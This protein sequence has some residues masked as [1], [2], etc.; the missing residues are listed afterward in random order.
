MK[1]NYKKNKVNIEDIMS[2]YTVIGFSGRLNENLDKTKYK[3]QI[4]EKLSIYLPNQ[5]LS[6][7]YLASRMLQ[8]GYGGQYIILSE[9]NKVKWFHNKLNIYEMLRSE[10]ILCDDNEDNIFGKGNTK[11]ENPPTDPSKLT[12]WLNEPVAATTTKRDVIAKIEETYPGLFA[13]API[14]TNKNCIGHLWNQFVTNV[15]PL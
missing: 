14:S 2:D 3:G 8:V 7:D 12:E 13:P 10:I 9:L 5:E 11:Y 4:F 1:L 15:F 6:Y